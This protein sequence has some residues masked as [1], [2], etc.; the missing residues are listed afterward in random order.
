MRRVLNVS[1][2]TMARELRTSRGVIAALEAGAVYAL[3]QWGETHRIV[4]TYAQRAGVDA[5][6][7]LARLEGYLIYSVAGES[8]AAPTK[9]PERSLTRALAL[10]Q[11]RPSRVQ[12][13]SARTQVKHPQ[14]S[15]RRRLRWAMKL[16]V[17]SLLLAVA[18]G[19]MIAARLKPDLLLETARRLPPQVATTALTSAELLVFRAAPHQDGLRWVDMADPRVRKADKLRSAGQ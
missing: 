18:G 4:V 19:I 2:D 17:C 5:R 12:P 16:A 14:G 10:Q 1:A 6:P 15:R 7:I 8:G 3:P 9:L 11:Q 13:D